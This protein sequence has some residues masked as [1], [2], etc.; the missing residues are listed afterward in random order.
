MMAERTIEIF[1]TG[2]VQRVGYRNFS[3]HC[4]ITCSI[5]GWTENLPDGRVHIIAKGQD[6]DIDAFID[7]LWAA[8]DPI[9]RVSHIDVHSAQVDISPGFF[10]HSSK[11]PAEEMQAKVDLIIEYF[12][13]VT[14][15]QQKMV[16]KIEELTEEL[17]LMKK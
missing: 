12:R 7:L 4:A 8:G 1:I 10:I 6:S 17:R 15:S 14:K 5:S 3:K 9:I 16:E 11:P 2:R 13:E